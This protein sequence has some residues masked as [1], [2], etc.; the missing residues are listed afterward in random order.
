MLNVQ[1]V[2]R[3]LSNENKRDF[4]RVVRGGNP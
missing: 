4:S 1:S 2:E 3:P